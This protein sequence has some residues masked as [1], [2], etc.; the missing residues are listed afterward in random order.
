MSNTIR[1]TERPDYDSSRILNICIVDLMVVDGVARGY[2]EMRKLFYLGPN[3]MNAAKSYCKK[4]MN[5]LKDARD[6]DGADRW[7]NYIAAA[8]VP[9]LKKAI[10]AVDINGSEYT[11]DGKIS[12]LKKSD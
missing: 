2:V 9:A 4:I 7:H 12:I 3:D 8:I 5:I 10:Y 1:V 11:G 6:K